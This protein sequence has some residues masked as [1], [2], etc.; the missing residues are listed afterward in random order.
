MRRVAVTGMG[1]TPLLPPDADATNRQRW[2]DA[3]EDGP[4]ATAKGWRRMSWSSKLAWHALQVAI[5]SDSDHAEEIEST[6]TGMVIGSRY[7]SLSLFEAFHEVLR[8]EGPGAVSPTVFTTG[9]LNAPVGH[10]SLG[11]GVQGPC[12]TLVG[13]EAAGLEAIALG[14]E[15]IQSGSIDRV[16]AIGV[17]EAPPI[18]REAL[19]TAGALPRD[20]NVVEGA[21]ALTLEATERPGLAVI[22]A[23]ATG[24]CGRRHDAVDAHARLLETVAGDSPPSRAVIPGCSGADGDRERTAVSR[25]L[26]S[27]AQIEDVGARDYSPGFL[28]AYA[29]QVAVTHLREGRPV[30]AT[31]AGGNGT[32]VAIRFD[33]PS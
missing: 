15:L 1:A 20:R 29:A 5:A 23:L 33:P 25:V 12:H 2:R 32:T 13:S 19:T 26:A 9:V 27:P 16:F 18:L 31:A 28:T 8:D 11:Q 14:W 24:R 22:G 17:E 4:L 10:A 21:T 6:R 3:I 30:I 7:G